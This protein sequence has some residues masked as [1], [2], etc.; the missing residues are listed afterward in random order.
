MSRNGKLIRAVGLW[1]LIAF[2]L[3]LVIGSGVYLLPSRTFELLGAASLWAP[4]VFAIPVFIL[5][6]CFAEASSRFDDSGGP[7]LYTRD[8][9]GEFLG[10]ETGW[11]N[12]VARVTS[13]ASLANG[14][15]LSLDRLVPGANEGLSR[16]L[17]LAASILI[18]SLIDALGIRFGARTIYALTWGK[19]IPLLIFVIAGLAAFRYNPLP[20]SFSLDV[21][22][23]DWGTTT[24]F[25][26]FAYGG[27]EN[28][29]VPAAEY[30]NPKRNVPIALLVSLLAI[31]SVYALVQFAAMATLP[32]LG[33]TKTPIADA[34]G[35]VLGEFGLTLITLGAILSII[36][37][38]MGSTIA[39]SRMIYALTEDR[40]PF[41]IFG[42]VFSTTHTPLYSIVLLACATVPVALAGTFA[43]LA[44]VSAGARLATYLFTAASL[45]RLRRL[46]DGYTNPGGLLIPILGVLISL[47]LLS[48]LTREQLTALGIA[49]LAGLVLYAIS[50]AAG[51]RVEDDGAEAGGVS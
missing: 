42:K 20:G 18:L 32:D 13:I 26:L 5:A 19:I 37:T 23:V 49:A 24:L 38:N 45:P 43:T 35:V 3:N 39:A 36:G 2:N 51:G 12:L 41:R 25:L 4:I 1:G 21:A 48:V 9:L 17:L 50:L 28:L 46:R 44:L 10:F 30:E 27:F 6:L 15:V 11:M 7:Y 8:G 40:P 31:A 22:A 34:A 14:F 33:A 29:G 16:S 47:Y